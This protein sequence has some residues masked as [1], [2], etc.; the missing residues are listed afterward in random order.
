MKKNK[1]NKFP[2]II[3]GTKI[4]DVQINQKQHF[5][6]FVAMII[7]FNIVLMFS[8]G[9]VLTH[10]YAW[11][12]WVLC[13]ALMFASW[14]LSFRAYSAVKV[15]H[16]CEL[17]D[18]ALVVNSIW[19]NTIVDLK[20]VCEIKVKESFLDK[21][22]KINTKSLQIKLVANRRKKFTI[23]FIEE[24]AEKLKWE[25]LKTIEDK[26]DVIVAKN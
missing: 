26:P 7:I 15:F 3:L 23:H 10:L 13:F 24:D 18:N 19:F 16:K 8:V 20:D 2:D 25:I 1:R 14:G 5:L 12:N 21:L 11:Y 17:Y 4:R 6:F 22:F 9:Y